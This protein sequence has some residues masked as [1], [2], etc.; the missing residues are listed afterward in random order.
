MIPAERQE[1]NLQMLARLVDAGVVLS[2]TCV[3]YLTGFLP[4]AGEHFD[5]SSISS[6]ANPV[7]Y[8]LSTPCGGPAPPFW[9]KPT[10]RTVS[11]LSK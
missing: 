5:H 6:A 3:P 11:K 4:L 10:H 7:R 9:K 8:G 2:G 1:A